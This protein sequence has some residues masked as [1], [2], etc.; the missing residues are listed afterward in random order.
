MTRTTIARRCAPHCAQS[1][2]APP[3]RT[4]QMGAQGCR[5][6]GCSKSETAGSSSAIGQESFVT[7]EEEDE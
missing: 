1:P 4:G 5:G 7:V 3:R 2:R 6:G